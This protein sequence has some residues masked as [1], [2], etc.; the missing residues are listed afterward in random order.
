MKNIMGLVSSGMVGRDPFDPACW[1]GSSLQLFTTLQKRKRLHSAVGVDIKL[2]QKLF[3]WAKNFNIDK[4]TWY[5]KLN[6]DPT[7]YNALTQAISKK[8]STSDLDN[9]VGLQIGGHQN[10]AR[11]TNYN[12]PV[13]SYHDG[14]IAGLMKSPFFNKALMP[15]ALKAFAYEK[16]VY[17]DMS[18]IFVMSEYWRKNF[19]EEFDVPEHKVV[20]VRFGVNMDIPEDIEKDF[21]LKNIVFI[22]SCFERKG[23]D[24]LVQAF[25]A[26]LC[27][28]PDARLH[29]IGPSHVPDVLKKDAL[30]QNVV[31]H[32]FLS[33]NIPDQKEKFISILKKGNLF[34]LPSLYEPFGNSVLEAM[35]YKMPAIATNNWSFPDI[36]IPGQ[37]GLLLSG[38]SV[39]ELTEA[40]Q[41]YLD[42]LDCAKKCGEKG[43]QLV[44]ERYTWDKTVSN[45][46]H[47]TDL[48]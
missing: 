22:G 3:F 40:M 43:R 47:E 18:K 11:A 29:I 25:H 38:E 33:K 27:K 2:F 39:E 28:H 46:L 30:T 4:W 12:I 41:Y 48:L 14:N 32:G 1:S 36:I 44:L 5:Q 34:A 23:G 35:L 26:L 6:L 20:N 45:I 17:R 7:Y 19:I 42:D 15:N 10:F 24:K 9:I 21:S 37:T 31:F 13:C 16:N 8:I